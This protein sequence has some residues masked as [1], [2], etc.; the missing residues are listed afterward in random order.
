MKKISE[1]NTSIELEKELE[2]MYKRRDAIMTRI[3]KRAK[4]LSAEHPDLTISLFGSNVQTGT[5][6]NKR[7]GNRYSKMVYL[8]VIKQIE[9]QIV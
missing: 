4:Q 2:A 3:V 8:D 9:A 1:L 6:L 7:I 5:L